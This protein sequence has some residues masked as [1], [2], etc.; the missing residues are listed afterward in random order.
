MFWPM[1]KRFSLEVRK[2]LRKFESFWTTFL[3]KNVHLDTYKSVVGTRD[4]HPQYFRS[5]CRSFYQFRFCSEKKAWIV[6]PKINVE[7]T[8]IDLILY[9]LKWKRACSQHKMPLFFLKF[10][11]IS[12]LSLNWYSVKG[13]YN[14]AVEFLVSFFSIWW[15]LL[16]YRKPIFFPDITIKTFCGQTFSTELLKVTEFWNYCQKF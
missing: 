2:H 15:W 10:S 7:S 6:S 12:T 13:K 5:K 11:A 9:L 16:W 8:R 3:S 1:F 4:K 14:S